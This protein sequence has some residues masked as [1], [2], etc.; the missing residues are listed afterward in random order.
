MTPSR[1]EKIEAMLAAEP[2]DQFLRYSLAMEFQK[3]KNHDQSLAILRDLI[4]EKPP[5]V[6][7]SFRAGQQLA[8]LGRLDEARAA[9][10]EGIE[11]AR[12]QGDAHAAG[13]MA[14]F[15]AS[16]GSYD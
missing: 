2:H 5:H 3:E 16:L 11:A 4:N 1:R 10:R 12:S 6:P 14:E 15:L 8:A 9:L 7:A 13:E